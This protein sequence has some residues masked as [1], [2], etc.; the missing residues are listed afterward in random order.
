MQILKTYQVIKVNCHG[1]I[2]TLDILEKLIEVMVSADLHQLK[3]GLRQNIFIEFSSLLLPLLEKKLK[4]ANIPYEINIE[5]KPN[6]VTSYPAI[7]IFNSNSWLSEN[8]IKQILSGLNY[9]PV[10]KINMGDSVQALTPVFTGN[11]NWIASGAHTDY[12]H[13]FIR[14]P[15]TNTIAKWNEMIH[16]KDI[17]RFSK[18]LEA[19]ILKFRLADGFPDDIN[20]KLIG[21]LKTEPVDSILNNEEIQWP[22]YILPY[23][24]GLNKYNDGYWLGIYRRDEWFQIDFLLDVIKLCKSTGIGELCIT[25]WK[26]LIIKKIGDADRPKWI[27]LL[28]FHS[29]NIRH[30]LNE[31]NFQVED[32]NE[33]SLRL[34]KFIV[35]HLN[36]DDV[37]TAGICFGIKSR[38][39]TEVFSNILIRKR[40]LIKLGKSGLLPVYDIL[41]SKDFNPHARTGLVYRSS[42]FKY[43]LPEELHGC[44]REY[45]RNKIKMT[46][47]AVVNQPITTLTAPSD[48][49][50]LYSYQCSRCK[51]IL[52]DPSDLFEEN[53]VCPVCHAQGAEIQKLYK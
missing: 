3:F 43:L 26:S 31:L 47:I 6:M 11:I 53:L 33:D 21:E 19:A 35:K 51:N 25:P 42:L 27:Q 13:L 44:I 1:G 34:K 39:K 16:T 37:R 24:E 28:N 36:E 4:E 9:D 20:T 10:L 32:I 17:L 41:L 38:P 2:L 7:S 18:V 22:D 8:K 52:N 40:H 12:W 45:Y 46:D 14:Y 49:N 29:I 50:T 5:D 48:S 30:S 23:Y 15:K